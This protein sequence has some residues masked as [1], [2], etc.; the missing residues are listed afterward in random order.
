MSGYNH[1]SAALSKKNKAAK[2]EGAS[3]EKMIIDACNY[4]CDKGIADVDKTPE[5]VRQISKKNERGQFWACYE[6]KAQPDFKGT[7]KG[8]KSI[9]FD[10]KSTITEKIAV[11]VLS[12]E[13]RKHLILH[14]RLGAK[15]GVLMCF[16]FRCFFFIP[17][18]TFLAAKELNG[19]AHW[20]VHDAALHGETVRHTGTILDFLG[21]IEWH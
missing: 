8:G 20:T 18:K 9:V 13:Q 16:S 5:P 7:I 14:D 4:Y 19:H 10:A 15:S 2:D 12:D 11:S 21:G 1:R 3:F 17:I 6:K